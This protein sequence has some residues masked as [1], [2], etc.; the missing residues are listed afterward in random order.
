MYFRTKTP[1]KTS[2][3]TPNNEDT[4]VLCLIDRLLKKVH[5]IIIFIA[6]LKRKWYL[7]AARN[8]VKTFWKNINIYLSLKIGSKNVCTEISVQN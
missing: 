6:N 2:K 4:K 3:K 7:G 5:S 1:M 8:V